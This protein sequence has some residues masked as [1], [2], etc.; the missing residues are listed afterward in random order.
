MRNCKHCDFPHH[1][2]GDGSFRCDNCD[3]HNGSKPAQNSTR[4]HLDNA[5]EKIKE[6]IEVLAGMEGFEPITAPEAYLLHVLKEIEGIA[7]RVDEIENSMESVN[8]N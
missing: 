6:I 1:F 5:Q 7:I 4:N 3:K 8:E 2:I